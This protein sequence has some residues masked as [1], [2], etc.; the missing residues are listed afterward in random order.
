MTHIC[1]ICN[2][3]GLPDYVNTP[4]VCPQC[5]SDLKPFM[6]L[7]SI[8]RPTT[9]KNHSFLPLVVSL[10]ALVLGILYVNSLFKSAQTSATFSESIEIL[11]D[12]IRNIKLAT[13]SSPPIS[14]TSEEGVIVHYKV[15]PGDCLSKIA[16]LFY[17]DW[18]MYKQIEIS[19]NLHGK[20][21]LTVGKVLNIKLEKQ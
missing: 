7:S 17:N 20:Y 18:K 19:N 14:K 3:A 13:V 15:K 6:L 10:I 9:A 4:T 11:Q 21:N 2:K 12:S 16:Q 5:N 8:S 1:P